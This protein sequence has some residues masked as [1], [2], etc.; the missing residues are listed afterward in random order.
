MIGIDVV[1]LVTAATESNWR[2]KGYLDKIFTKEE[3]ALIQTSA[4][5][6]EM[7][8]LLWSMKEAAYKIYSRTTGVNSFAPTSLV[9]SNLSIHQQQAT[10]VV[11]VANNTFHTQSNWNKDY[12][13]SVAATSEASLKEIKPLL[14]TQ[15]NHV[16]YK[17]NSPKSVSHHGRYLALVY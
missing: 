5:G 2:R 11:T 14:Y 4:K 10:G 12:V 13:L 7:V 17:H 3:Q 9:C 6:D 16:A 15:P 8:W 1:D